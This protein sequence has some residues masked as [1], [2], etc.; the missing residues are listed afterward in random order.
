ML[1]KEAYHQLQ[2]ELLAI[3]DNREASVIAD[4]IMEEITTWTKSQRIVHH[5]FNFNQE[6]ETQF[7]K[8]KDEILAGKPLQYV[9]GYSWFK[10]HKFN[11]NEHVLIPRPE[12]EELVDSIIHYT[13]IVKENN[14]IP[15]RVLDIGTGSGCIAISLQHQFPEWEVWAIDKSPTAL[16]LALQNATHL[17]AKIHFKA[18]DILSESTINDLPSFNIIVSNPPYIPHE[19]KHE[20]TSQVLDHEPHLALFVT[21]NDPLQFYKAIISFSEQHLTRGGTLWFETHMAY[22]EEVAT[23]MKLHNYEEVKVQKDFQGK[24]RI[25]S[26]TRAGASL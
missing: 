6:Q 25:V 16:K 5:D 4:W 15:F 26:G 14:N 12:T 7:L 10:G 17:N 24:D 8:F 1:L 21:N 18:I 19:D 22:A 2:S 13:K 20:M 23:L 3:Y 9:L 11:V